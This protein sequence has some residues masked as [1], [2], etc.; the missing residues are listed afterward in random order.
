MLVHPFEQVLSQ[1]LPAAFERPRLTIGNA[2]KLLQDMVGCLGDETLGL[3]A[4]RAL[5]FGDGGAIDYAMRASAT[6][7]QALVTCSRFIRVLNGELSVSIEKSEDG[8]FVGLDSHVANPPASEDFMMAA[9]YSLHVSRLLPRGA[10]RECFFIQPRPTSHAEHSRTFSD[11]SLHFDCPRRGFRFESKHL[12]TPLATAEPN[13][14]FVMVRYLER[15]M[16]E[17][18]DSE[19]FTERIHKLL[20][21]QTPLMDSTLNE[22]ANVLGMA[23]RTLARRLHDEATSFGEAIDHVRR[24]RAQKYLVETSMSVEQISTALGFSRGAAF[25]RAFRRWTGQ[26]PGAYRRALRGGGRSKAQLLRRP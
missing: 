14:H 21:Q 15:E 10:S 23:P 6:V 25:H 1:K 20:M 11:A 22:I 19:S 3:K 17:L 2:H 12:A 16:A 5:I 26:S 7:E 4:G 8:V 9:F 13:L 18:P 24:V